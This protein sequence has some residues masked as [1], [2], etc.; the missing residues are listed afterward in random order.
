VCGEWSAKDLAG[1]L[2][3]VI[4]WYHD[5][6]D[7]AERG[8]SKPPF[9]A[10]NLP[11][12]NAKALAAL[13]DGTGHGRIERYAAEAKRYATRLPDAWDIPYGYPYG[14]AT[15]GLHAG[16]A[17]CE[18]HLHAWDLSAGKHRPAD[19]QSLFEAVGRAITAERWARRH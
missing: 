8:T 4:G 13:A 19:P 7:A 2:V 9:P 14:T 1:H 3:C 6:L 12:E 18:W 10:A 16:A 11:A 15:A 17:A 5:W